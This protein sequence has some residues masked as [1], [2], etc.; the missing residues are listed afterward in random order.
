MKLSRKNKEKYVYFNDTL[1]GN[2]GWDDG[3]KNKQGMDKGADGREV[4][5]N[6]KKKKKGRKEKE[7]KGMEQ[8]QI[9]KNIQREG[10]KGRKRH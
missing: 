6:E 10:L 7:T 4:N 8:E 3:V 9:I 2:G 1:T 5:K